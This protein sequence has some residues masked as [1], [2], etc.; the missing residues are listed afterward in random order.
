MSLRSYLGANKE[1]IQKYKDD[2]VIEYQMTLIEN[3][4]NSSRL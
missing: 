1:I 4:I 3:I 2:E